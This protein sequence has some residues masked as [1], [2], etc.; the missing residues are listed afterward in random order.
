MTNCAVLGLIIVF[1][2]W[3]LLLSFICNCIVI[4]V[5]G[6]RYSNVLLLCCWN[7]TNRW[8]TSM[9]FSVYKHC[10]K[11]VNWKH[12]TFEKM[13][14]Y[15]TKECFSPDNPAYVKLTQITCTKQIRNTFQVIMKIKMQVCVNYALHMKKKNKKKT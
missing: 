10:N 12:S 1:L 14:M 3:L 8:W 2:I 6:V 4:S 5:S 15:I 13:K 7:K 11:V 9:H